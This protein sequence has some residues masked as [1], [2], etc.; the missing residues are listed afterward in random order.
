MDEAVWQITEDILL[1]Q[2]IISAPLDLKTVYTNEFVEKA[3]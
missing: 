1:E 2:G 3:Q